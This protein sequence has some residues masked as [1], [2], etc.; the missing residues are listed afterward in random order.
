MQNDFKEKLASVLL[1]TGI[2]VFIGLFIWWFRFSDE[3]GGGTQDGCV[4]DPLYGGCE[5]Y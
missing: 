3:S 5:Q 1:I 2:I 4:P